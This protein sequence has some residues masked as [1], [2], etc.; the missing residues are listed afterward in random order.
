MKA[1]V[2]I[3]F[4]SIPL[5]KSKSLIEKTATT[6]DVLLNRMELK[7]LFY[8][9]NLDVNRLFLF[10]TLISIICDAKDIVQFKYQSL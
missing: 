10:L 3:N 8:C 6:N 2:Y 9:S 5:L 4:V 1:R 7:Y